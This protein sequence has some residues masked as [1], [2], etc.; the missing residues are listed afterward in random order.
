MVRELE[1]EIRKGFGNLPIES[2]LQA[3]KHGKEDKE[4]IDQENANPRQNLCG[5]CHDHGR[6]KFLR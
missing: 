1:R 4:E 5:T 6:P 3:T 2:S